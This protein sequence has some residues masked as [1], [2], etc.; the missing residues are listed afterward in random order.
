[1]NGD[2]NLNL[3]MSLEL[4]SYASGLYFLLSLVP[5]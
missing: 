5:Y 2:H 3:I 1:M 4:S